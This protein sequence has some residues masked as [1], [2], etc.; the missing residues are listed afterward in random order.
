MPVCPYGQCT[1]RNLCKGTHCVRAALEKD[2]W[3]RMPD[4]TIEKI[5]KEEAK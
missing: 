1:M 4:G 3:Q 5:T 2:G